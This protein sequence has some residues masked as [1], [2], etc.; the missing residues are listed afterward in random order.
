MNEATERNLKRKSQ[1]IDNVQLVDGVP[2]FSWIDLNVTE[3]CG[4][5]CVF[6]PRHEGQYP[7]RNLNM[8]VGLAEK[9][10]HELFFLDYEGT[11]VFCGFG[12][13]TLHPEFA[14]LVEAFGRRNLNLELVTNGDSLDASRIAELF[15][16]GII[17]FAVSL[18]DGPEQLEHF[19]RMFEQAAVPTSCYALR[20][21]WYGAV[22]D[23]GLKLT[24]RAGK[25]NVGRQPS[26]NQSR[27]CF[28]TAYSTIID[29]NGDVLLC[30]QDWHKQKVF[31]NVHDQSLFDI[32]KNSR[33]LSGMRTR[34]SQ[35]KRTDFPCS[36]CN[37]DGCLHGANHVEAW[38]KK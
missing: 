16:V 26:V 5:N 15:A 7:N 17:F 38:R 21:R 36:L 24:N 37:A 34:L 35:G 6:C 10:A 25:V 23:Y 1:F 14:Q 27:P 31:G 30:P 19:Q 4:R 28:Y 2:L 29:W 18:Y 12:E 32:W 8:S 22:E 11:V 9:L 3:L 13:P 33:D 20:D